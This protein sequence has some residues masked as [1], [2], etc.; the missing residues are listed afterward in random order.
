MASCTVKEL[1]LKISEIELNY[2]ISTIEKISLIKNIR[3]ELTKVNI[4][5]D[6]IKKEIIIINTHYIN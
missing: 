5:V 4:E 6:D 1:L 3:E 2:E